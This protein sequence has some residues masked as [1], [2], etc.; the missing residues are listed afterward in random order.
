MIDI[1]IEVPNIKTMVNTRYPTRKTMVN[2]R[3]SK[4][5]TMGNQNKSLQD[6]SLCM[7]IVSS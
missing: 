5:S 4:G 6:V 1:L 2:M 7:Q 3:T